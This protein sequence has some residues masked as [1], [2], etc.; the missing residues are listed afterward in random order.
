VSILNMPSD[1]L[2]NV[3]IVLSR[4]LVRFGPKPRAELLKACGSEVA[5][6]DAKQLSQTLNRWTE[7][8]LF[9]VENLLVSLN[10]PHRSRLGKIPDLAEARLP[11]VARDIALA[12]ENNERFWEAEENRSADLSRG[13]AW[14]LA[15][16]IYEVETGSHTKVATFEREQVADLS[17]HILQNDTRWNGLRTWMLFLGFAR[18]GTQVSIDPTVALRDALPR[19]L[20]E[21]ETIPATLFVERAAQVLPVLDGGAYRLK[22]EE[23]LLGSSWKRPPDGQLS[24]SF[25]RAIQRLDRA[26]LIATEKKSDSEQGVTLTGA[27]QR[28][29]HSFTHIRRIDSKRVS[30]V[31]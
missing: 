13:L 17:K 28:P 31:A 22:V 24:T 6:I 21:R 10:E 2:F 23:I 7:C 15:Q 12:A 19:L 11:A 18:G 14:I 9:S 4:A 26:G 1:G 8:G 20:D 5:A 27:N 3:L 30:D 25:S 16:D 29:W